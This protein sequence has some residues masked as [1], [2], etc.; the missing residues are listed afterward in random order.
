MTEPTPNI[1]A[2]SSKK[3]SYVILHRIAAS[4]F[5]TTLHNNTISIHSH[6]SNVGTLSAYMLIRIA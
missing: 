4:S 5:A 3:S 2:H 1:H 6:L